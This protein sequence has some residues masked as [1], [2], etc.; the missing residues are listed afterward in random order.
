MYLLKAKWITIELELSAVIN[1]MY[2]INNA[3]YAK[4]MTLN[5]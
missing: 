2:K 1:Y 4:K 3:T 5:R